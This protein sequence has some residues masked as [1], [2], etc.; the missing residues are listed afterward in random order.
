MY[1][2]KCYWLFKLFIKTTTRPEHTLT[3]NAK[4][5][6]SLRDV[7]RDNTKSSDLKISRELRFRYTKNRNGIQTHNLLVRK[8]KLN[9]LAKLAKWLRCVVSAYRSVTFAYA[10]LIMS[11]SR[12]RVNLT[13]Q[14]PECQGIPC[15]K[16][17][18]YLTFNMITTHS[19]KKPLTGYRNINS[20]NKITDVQEMIGRLQ[21]DCFLISESM[22]TLGSLLV[23]FTR[24]PMK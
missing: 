8:R 13:L 20:R 18:R 7:Y 12:I 11:Y 5:N 22:L 9:H 17:A 6:R 2:S 1:F 15:P 16:Q 24:G 19:P 23:K 10:S 14:V 4:I 3:H 21:L